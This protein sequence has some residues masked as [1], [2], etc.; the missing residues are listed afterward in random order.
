MKL[1]QNQPDQVNTITGY[2]F[3]F[4]EI[5]KEAY[6]KNLLLTASEMLPWDVVSFDALCPA[7]LSG[8]LTFSPAL[9][10]LGTGQTLRFP[11][12]SLL[13]DLTKAQVGVEV[14][15]TQAA[16]RTFNVLAAEGRRVLLAALID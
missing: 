13:A 15:D 6:T 12:P 10:L 7:D 3:G 4:I 11:H 9:V 14:M 2:G 8:L 1:H 5:N 16:C